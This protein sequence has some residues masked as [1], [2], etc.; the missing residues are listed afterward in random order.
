MTSPAADLTVA[1]MLL[2][3]CLHLTKIWQ[4]NSFSR[5]DLGLQ[6]PWKVVA[7]ADAPYASA[8]RA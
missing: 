1:L 5:L 3:S 8:S 2:C 4:I 6:K 7:A